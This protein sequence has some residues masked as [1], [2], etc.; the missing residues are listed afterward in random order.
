MSDDLLMM[1]ISQSLIKDAFRE[2]SPPLPASRSFIT[3]DERTTIPRKSTPLIM[4]WSNDAGVVSL[5][6][7][8]S[9]ES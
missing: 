3:V 1:V 5:S 2:L 7:F 9:S 8:G 6:L 4:E